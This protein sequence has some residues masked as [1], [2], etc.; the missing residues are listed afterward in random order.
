MGYAD[1]D[2]TAGA[3]DDRDFAAQ[4]SHFCPHW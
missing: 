4:F 2:A 3:G 1:A